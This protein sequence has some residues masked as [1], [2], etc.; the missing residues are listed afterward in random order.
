MVGWILLIFIAQECNDMH[1]GLLDT[2]V[3]LVFFK[4]A[5]P[6]KQLSLL[7]DIHYASLVLKS[8]GSRCLQPPPPQ[9]CPL[10]F[11]IVPK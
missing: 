4:L 2:K 6:F 10:I 9:W 8:S 5:L 7:F 1:T 3:S 11:L